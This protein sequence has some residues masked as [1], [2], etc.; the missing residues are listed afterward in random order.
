M[1]GK[2]GKFVV[3]VRVS[4]SPQEE[5]DIAGHAGGGVHRTCGG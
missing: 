4:G 3:Y 5:G 1:S 2:K